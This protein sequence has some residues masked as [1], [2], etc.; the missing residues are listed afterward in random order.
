MRPRPSIHPLGAQ[1][2][3][4]GAHKS[5]P[6]AGKEKGCG[7][8]AGPAHGNT[9]LFKRLYARRLWAWVQNRMEIL[10]APACEIATVNFQRRPAVFRGASTRQWRPSAA[11]R[12]RPARP[13][14]PDPGEFP[15]FF[16]GRFFPQWREYSGP[17]LPGRIPPPAPPKS[18]AP[19]ARLSRCTPQCGPPPWQC[20]SKWPPCAG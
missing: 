2:S 3:V 16:P 14:P 13:A 10:Y 1:Q 7:C 15:G 11:V 8:K 19:R 6:A 12:R 20:R 18:E 17:A 5:G 9:S 4:A